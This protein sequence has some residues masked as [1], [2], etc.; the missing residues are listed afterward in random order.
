MR[1]RERRGQV[2]GRGARSVEEEEGRREE[3]NGER[4]LLRK[5]E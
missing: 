2:G 5:G 3:D 4:K 1:E